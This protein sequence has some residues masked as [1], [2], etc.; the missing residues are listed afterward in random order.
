MYFCGKEAVIKA[1]SSIGYNDIFRNKI[2]ISEKM[3]NVFE[4]K[5]LQKPSNIKLSI[6][7]SL[8]KSKAIAY[9]IAFIK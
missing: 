3:F 7:L 2:D 4:V 5:L 8:N 1:L 6:S 9:A